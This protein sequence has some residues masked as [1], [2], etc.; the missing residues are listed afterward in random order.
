MWPQN[1]C[2]FFQKIVQTWPNLEQI[3]NFGMLECGRLVISLPAVADLTDVLIYQI[4]WMLPQ[5]RG[6]LVVA[7]HLGFSVQN[8]CLADRAPIVEDISCR[9]HF[10]TC[11]FLKCIFKSSQND[12]R[13][14]ILDIYIFQTVFFRMTDQLTGVDT[15]EVIIISS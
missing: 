9:A 6:G 15:R 13:P 2:W 4:L 12:V 1:I 8:S 14:H 10:P 7:L 5:Y 11:I 3:A